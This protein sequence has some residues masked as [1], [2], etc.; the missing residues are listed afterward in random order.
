MPS[1]DVD[2]LVAPVSSQL[3]AEN[4][5]LRRFTRWAVT[6]TDA[7]VTFHVLT[8]LMSIATAIPPYIETKLGVGRQQPNI[9]GMIVGESGRARKSWSMSLSQKLLAEACPDRLGLRIGSYEAAVASLVEKPYMTIFE[10]EF[11][12]FLSQS[13]GNAQGYLASLKLG[14]TDMY[15]LAPLSRKTMRVTHN[16]TDYRINILGAISDSYLSEYTEPSDFTGGFLSRW[17]FASGDRTRFVAEPDDSPAAEAEQ[18]EL[19]GMLQALYMHAPTGQYVFEPDTR[20][21]FNQ[22]Q[23]AIDEI[24]G[25]V[26]HRLVG[27][28]DRSAALAKRV[29]TLLAIDRIVNRE[30]HREGTFDPILRWAST[31][32]DRARVWS[33]TREDLDTTLQIIAAHLQAAQRIVSKVEHSAAA[34]AKAKVLHAM[35]ETAA[36]PIGKVTRETGMNKRD[37]ETVLDTLKFEDRVKPIVVNGAN[38]WVRLPEEKVRLSGLTANADGLPLPQVAARPEEFS[39]IPLGNALTSTGTNRDDAFTNAGLPPA[40]TPLVSLDVIRMLEDE[41]GRLSAPLDF[42]APLGYGDGDR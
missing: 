4:S 5:F 22:W 36:V 38:W 15:D 33:V 11:S 1:F 13:K 10:S 42:Q 9:F 29:A 6:Q 2:A 40:P 20:K 28:V 41:D 37:V 27:M 30:G 34:K 14:L 3:G 35:P 16:V 31:P 17:L 21:V 18:K 12:R 23:E 24:G 39:P 32:A 25:S 19:V 8:G 7:P 26:E